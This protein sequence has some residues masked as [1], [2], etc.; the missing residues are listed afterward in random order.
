MISR[1]SEEGEAFI[2]TA[3]AAPDFAM[4]QLDGI[5]DGYDGRSIC[6]K[7]YYYQTVECPA[8]KSTVFVITPTAGVSHW[9]TS[10]NI[11]TDMING[12]AFTAVLYPDAEQVFGGVEFAAGAGEQKTNTN[13]VDRARVVSMA[14]E[15]V[16]LTNS[17]HQYGS[18]S[19]WKT[20]LS[21]TIVND[22]GSSAGVLERY[23]IGGVE[24]LVNAQLSAEAQVSP[25]R[26]GTYSVS[27]NRENEFV[28]Q[29]VMDN[30]TE[31]SVTEGLFA[32]PGLTADKTT[33]LGP[34]VAFDNGFDSI[35]IRVDVPV[36]VTA[37]SFVLKTWKVFEYQPVFNSLLYSMAGLSAEHNPASLELYSEIERHLP[38]AVPARDNPDFWHTM[39]DI[40]SETSNVLSYVPGNIG[41]AAKGVHGITQLFSSKSQPRSSNKAKK[42]KTKART[43]K[44]KGT[45]KK[46]RQRRK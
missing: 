44:K 24:G 23:G 11:G 20:P 37:Q 27:M 1:V 21:H 2:K 16:C 31:N 5:P 8:G 40:I 35:V 9:T 33:W 18:I 42:K 36:D 25:V 26:D 12:Q 10:L 14:A 15:M 41:I 45:N 29:D 46:A 19:T 38:V 32:G 6:K 4:T 43:K 7:D 39:L 3:T 13:M 22:D 30:Q 28:W 34:I 17:F